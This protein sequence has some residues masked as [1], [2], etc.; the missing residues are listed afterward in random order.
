M[1]SWLQLKRNLLR[2]STVEEK[3]TTLSCKSVFGRGKNVWETFVL[4]RA[5]ICKGRQKKRVNSVQFPQGEFDWETQI[6]K[7]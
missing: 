3:D 7:D 6:S 1:K 5:G 4:G 2:G